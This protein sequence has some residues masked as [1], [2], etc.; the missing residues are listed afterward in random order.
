MDGTQQFENRTPEAVAS[1]AGSRTHWQSLFDSDQRIIRGT[2]DSERVVWRTPGGET[3]LSSQRFNDL[4]RLSNQ[5]SQTTA[6]PESVNSLSASRASRADAAANRLATTN[7]LLQSRAT[8][9]EWQANNQRSSPHVSL[10]WD[11]AGLEGSHSDMSEEAEVTGLMDRDSLTP[12]LLREFLEDLTKIENG[13]QSLREPLL[14]DAKVAAVHRLAISLNPS[15]LA[16]TL[17]FSNQQTGARIRRL[18]YVWNIQNFSCIRDHAALSALPFLQ[19]FIESEEFG[20]EDA[21]KFYLMLFPYGE[22]GKDL[23]GVV[24]KVVSNNKH[25]TTARASFAVL[26]SKGQEVPWTKR[27]FDGFKWFQTSLYY[28]SL[29]LFSDTDA[30]ELTTVCSVDDSLRLKCEL[31]VCVK[32][33]D[34]SKNAIVTQTEVV[35]KSA[36][37]EFRKLMSEAWTHQGGDAR[38]LLDL[39][40]L[41]I[42]ENNEKHTFKANSFALAARSKVFRTMLTGAFQEG[43]KEAIVVKD[44]CPLILQEALEFLHTDL[45]PFFLDPN[46]SHRQVCD[47]MKFADRFDCEA[48]KLHCLQFLVNCIGPKTA[49]ELYSVAKETGQRRLAD[50]CM[51]QAT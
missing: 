22:S 3:E 29:V 35:S 43:L 30:E 26:N 42:D 13:G 10:N 37:I 39:R 38:S 1:S 14:S 24:V 17:P 19:N 11:S 12:T 34:T 28:N 7:T 9:S 18:T 23:S 41:C 33:S 25:S 8:A 32:I 5:G 50:A 2:R 27:S 31:E 20:D 46:T 48:L 6:S 51:S 40:I 47:L 45:C 44:V 4:H 21:G 49:L 15:P 36:P 16:N